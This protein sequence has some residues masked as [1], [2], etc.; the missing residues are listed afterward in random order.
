MFMNISE[1]VH[2]IKYMYSYNMN[3]PIAKVNVEL[4]PRITTGF[5]FTF[6]SW[7]TLRIDKSDALQNFML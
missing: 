5:S 2:T 1:C 6:S 7:D 3:K 4:G